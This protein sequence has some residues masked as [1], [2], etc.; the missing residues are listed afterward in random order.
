MGT[1]KQLLG[2]FWEIQEYKI[3]NSWLTIGCKVFGLDSHWLDFLRHYL[4]CLKVPK[5][6]EPLHHPLDQVSSIAFLDVK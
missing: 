2:F 6:L 4:S 5:I 3:W 1:L